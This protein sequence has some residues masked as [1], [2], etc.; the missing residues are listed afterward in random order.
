MNLDTEPGYDLGDM[1]FYWRMRNPGEGPHPRVPAFLPFSF[2]FMP[3]LQLV[4]QKR[5]TETLHWL[6]EIY[7]EDQNVGYLQEGHSLAASYGDDFLGFME[8]ACAEHG[9]A[10]RSFIEVGCGGGYLLARL[11][12]QGYRVKGVDPSPVSVRAAEALGVPMM[13]DFY[14]STRLTDQA[15][16][17]FHYDVLEHVADPVGFL[18]AHR[19]NLGASGHVVIAV[20]D[21][22]QS[23]LRGDASMAIHEHLN[24]FDADSLGRTLSQ[25][26]FIPLKIMPSGYGGV[27]YALARVGQRADDAGAAS[28][29]LQ[30]FRRFTRQLDAF[31]Q[32]IRTFAA[33]HGTGAQGL[34]L[35]IPLRLI[36]YIAALGA[37]THMRFFDD[38]PGILGKRF[39]GYEVPV[40]N[41]SGFAADPPSGVVIG[42]FP[43]GQKIA[44]RI[45]QALGE[46]VEIV[47]LEGIAQSARPD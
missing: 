25:A 34:G 35:Y 20:P 21:C 36:P 47:T 3:G 11:Q 19:A 17:I 44:T 12:K 41:F 7:R 26:G 29:D 37:V 46:R 18:A 32:A 31:R 39:D 42:S 30:K 8:S 6:D 9:V 1:A 45:R 33:R 14:P 16:V 2:S 22:T 27:L 24:Y 28:H 13:A 10:P 38:D 4:I 43:F 5:R 23:I 15:D 40:E